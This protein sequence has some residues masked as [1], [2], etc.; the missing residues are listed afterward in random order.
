MDNL[1][2]S[3]FSELNLTDS[4]FDSLRAN[5]DG[6]DDWY[7]RKSAAGARAYTYVDSEGRIRDFLYLKEETDPL[8]MA[9]N[10]LPAVRRLKVGTFKIERRGTNRGE[11]FIKK[12]LDQ[13]VAFDVEEVYVTMFNDEE[14]LIH[15]RHFFEK[16]GFKEVGTIS[17][18]S[19]G[20]SEVVLLRT[21]K[22]LQGDAYK[23]FPYLDKEQ[24]E[25]YLLSIYPAYHTQLFSDS[26]LATES[27]DIVQ[28]VSESNSVTKTYICWMPDVINM[29][30][31]DKV[32]IYR[33]NDYKGPAYFRSVATSL[34]TVLEVK[35][36]KNFSDVEEFVR[37]SSKNSVFKDADLRKWYSG[38]TCYVIKML[39]NVAFK[40]RVIRKTMIE[41]LG[42]PQDLYWGFFKLTDEQFEG[43]LQKGNADER[44]FIHQA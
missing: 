33:T 12:I 30:P 21:M 11:R 9:E 10:T 29:V 32:I 4:F 27:Y 34:C 17:H 40:T 44:Y 26:M 35:T 31:G 23:D 43:I 8:V 13:A 15:L 7:G 3:L 39:Y 20:R 2:Y 22:E 24:G 42:I 18:E 41:E 38:K 16:Y 14:E 6:F 5:Y 25:K 36:N 28:D 19:N 1:R 37:Y